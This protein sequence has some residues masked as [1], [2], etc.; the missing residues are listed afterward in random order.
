MDTRVTLT[1]HRGWR[2]KYPENTMLSFR[3]ALEL[4][5]DGIEM[6]VHMT[7][8]YHIVVCH[9]A[10]LD[11]TTD[12][13]GMISRMTL[14]EVRKADAGIRFGEEFKGEKVPTFEEFLE[15]KKNRN[16]A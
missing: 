16:Q 2:S 5:I 14:E 3:K 6:D 8:D 9:D 15:W 10:T 12:S 4:D 11:R 7:G 13:T 1:A